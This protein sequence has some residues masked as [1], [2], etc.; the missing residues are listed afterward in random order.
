MLI[1]KAS[2]ELLSKMN[3]DDGE[4]NAGSQQHVVWKQCDLSCP[5]TSHHTF[6]H[7]EGINVIQYNLRWNSHYDQLHD[8]VFNEEGSLM[9]GTV[10][11][12]IELLIPTRRYAPQH[13]YIFAVLISI[14]IFISPP[15]LLQ[16]ILQLCVF[17]QNATAVN[18]TKEERTRTFCGI[19][20]LCLE[21]TQSI[22]Y[23]FCDQQ[24]QRR[25]MELLN[26]CSIDENCKAHIN[27]LF[28]Q[29]HHALNRAERFERA[30]AGISSST[31]Q[32]FTAKDNQKRLVEICPNPTILARQ[33][34]LIELE[35]LSMIGPD[36]IV[37]AV[38]D[39][40]ARKVCGGRMNN[41]G[42]YIDWF[43]RL[44]Y[45]TA[46]EILRCS[47]RRCRVHTIQYFIEVAQECINFGNFNSFM[48]VVAALSL[49]LIGRLKKTWSRVEKSK[50]EILL[51]QYDPTANFASYRST[52]KAAIWR[53]NGAQ[54]ATDVILIP[55]F[56]LLIKDFS[57]M[58]RQ[59]AQLLL[60]GHINF[61]MFSQ[62]GSEMLNFIKW[63][64]RKC[65]FEH[66]NHT[67]QQLLLSK[68]FSEKQL[69][70]LS[71]KFEMAEQTAKKEHYRQLKV[72]GEA[73]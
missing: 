25:L 28:E 53:F 57:L 37:Y 11:A 56:G 30:L 22:P 38:M 48:A 43:N 10:D 69:I 17:E 23:D 33:M 21:W 26:L 44:T 58:H 66:D 16:K 45:L 19:Y 60:N 12:L 18:F 62:F 72:D 24:M 46:T 3:G 64:S 27:R 20:R 5:S 49:P 9:S 40:D 15:D 2:N 14:R 70:K 42:H 4:G 36:E 31:D 34:T 63:K 7:L 41:I 65:S 39:D 35:R 51:H 47:K 50:L 29:L 67:L 68:T 1:S 54:N 8:R 71:Y 32:A 61:K 52:L 13:S 59:C 73:Q 55:F 6:K